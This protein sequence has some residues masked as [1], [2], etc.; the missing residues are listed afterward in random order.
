MGLKTTPE[1]EP[2]Q[3]PSGNGL[4]R[5]RSHDSQNSSQA[6]G[7]V[8]RGMMNWLTTSTSSPTT[9]STNGRQR[10]RKVGLKARSSAARAAVNRRRSTMFQTNLGFRKVPRRTR[11]LRPTPQMIR[12]ARRGAL[13]KFLKGG[14]IIRADAYGDIVNPKTAELR[15]NDI[16]NFETD[17]LSDAD[18]NTDQDLKTESNLYYISVRKDELPTYHF[19]RKTADVDPLLAQKPVDWGAIFTDRLPSPSDKE[20]GLVGEPGVPA[21]TVSR[22]VENE[23]MPGQKYYQEFNPK[24][25]IR[26]A[27]ANQT[28]GT[29][30]NSEVVEWTVQGSI[31]D[32]VWNTSN[33][34]I[35]EGSRPSGPQPGDSEWEMAE[36]NWEARLRAAESLQAFLVQ[37]GSDESAKYAELTA[38]ATSPELRPCRGSDSRAQIFNAVW[39][40]AIPTVAFKLTQQQFGRPVSPLKGNEPHCRNEDPTNWNPNE[41]LN[42]MSQYA[43][44]EPVYHQEE[45]LE[46]LDFYD[47]K[48][49]GQPMLRRRKPIP[50]EY[51]QREQPYR[52]EILH[53]KGLEKSVVRMETNSPVL[54]SSLKNAFATSK[55]FISSYVLLQGDAGGLYCSTTS[56][57]SFQA[58]CKRLLPAEAS[59]GKGLSYSIDIKR[60]GTSGDTSVQV[61]EID[62]VP[63]PDRYYSQIKPLL[64]VRG[65][66]YRVRLGG[67]SDKPFKD[68]DYTGACVKLTARNIGYAWIDAPWEDDDEASNN[69]KIVIEALQFL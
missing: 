18:D 11:P 43:R 45:P 49:Y 38:R 31:A 32:L 5:K 66:E 26:P 8:V 53:P 58:I 6:G 67:E 68:T 35:I 28:V 63:P 23:W 20:I 25:S 17:H 64:E 37:Y 47:Q 65:Q 42:E 16:Y 3:L 36:A 24:R 60:R 29:S 52:S 10:V 51:I 22:T 57:D 21:T 2:E 33:N 55:K 44:G 27:V 9:S 14:E 61:L 19:W 46:F 56:Y 13:T 39:K 34:G 4:D 30:I 12:S 59:K 62:E 48:S 50:E 1:K 41:K 54:G 15:L 69:S 40:T 7:G